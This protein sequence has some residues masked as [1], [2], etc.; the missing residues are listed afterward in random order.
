MTP[1]G[2]YQYGSSLTRPVTIL[3]RNRGIFRCSTRPDFARHPYEVWYD[4]GGRA[5]DGSTD[6]RPL[7]TA[8]A[9]RFLSGNE[10]GGLGNY[11]IHTISVRN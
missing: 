6:S 5:A 7:Q 3:L 9:R 10:S 4:C 8:Y 2:L 11:R 1:R